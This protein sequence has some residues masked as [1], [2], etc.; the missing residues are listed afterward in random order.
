MNIE[1]LNQLRELLLRDKKSVSEL[2][3]TKN[4]Y[5][6]KGNLTEE[7]LPT[8]TTNF[9]EIGIC[10]GKIYF[11]FIIDSKTF[12]LKFFNKLKNKLNV[13]LYG[14]V[15]FNKTLYPVDDFNFDKL[16]KKIQKDKYLQIQFD[17]KNINAHDL[18]K[19]YFDLVNIFKNNKIVIIDQLKINLTKNQNEKEKNCYM[20]LSGRRD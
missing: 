5:D 11:V 7:Y 15:K 10:N 12:G 2:E 4:N 3:Y 13:K 19:K 16:M 6:H 9:C 20:P 17:Y 1:N 14:F 8:I 18:F